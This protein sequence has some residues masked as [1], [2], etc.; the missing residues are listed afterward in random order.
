MH[1]KYLLVIPL[2]KGQS[3]CQA[4]NDGESVWLGRRSPRG[5]KLNSESQVARNPKGIMSS[6]EWNGVGR[7]EKRMGEGP[8]GQA[9]KGGWS[10]QQA[11]TALTGH[12]SWGEVVPKRWGSSSI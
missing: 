1:G 5:R 7:G 6:R 3:L 11:G 4:G 10:E 9:E 12:E 8:F 2:S